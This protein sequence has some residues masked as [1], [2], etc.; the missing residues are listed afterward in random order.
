MV[1]ASIFFSNTG[2]LAVR[3]WELSGMFLTQISVRWNGLSIIIIELSSIVTRYRNKIHNR[4]IKFIIKNAMKCVFQV[5]RLE[6]EL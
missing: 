5:F 2:L 3:D 4:K 1:L 6:N